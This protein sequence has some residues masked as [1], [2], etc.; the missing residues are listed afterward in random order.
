[1]W[2]GI[3][4]WSLWGKPGPK[5]SCF[6]ITTIRMPGDPQGLGPILSLRVRTNWQSA[7]VPVKPQPMI[8]KV[9]AMIYL[10]PFRVSPYRMLCC[11]T[12]D[13]EKLFFPPT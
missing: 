6:S 2:Q 8:A 7:E 13:M 4:N 1:M 10:N 9:N 3:T 12:P 5:E 11:F